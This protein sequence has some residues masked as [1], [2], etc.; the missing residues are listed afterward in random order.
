[1]SHVQFGRYDSQKIICSIK[2]EHFD[3]INF[4]II[5]FSMVF[6]FSTTKFWKITHISYS[7][8]GLFECRSY[9]L[10][11]EFIHQMWTSDEWTYTCSTEESLHFIN[12][13]SQHLHLHVA[14]FMLWQHGLRSPYQI[15]RSQHCIILLM[16]K[17]GKGY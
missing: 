3:K 14:F 10:K 1:M 2:K 17:Q 13:V 12:S 16:G 4:T 9:L 7:K 8:F 15:K 11:K 5:I 6:T